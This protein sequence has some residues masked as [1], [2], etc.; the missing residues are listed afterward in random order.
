MS[1]NSKSTKG[2][3]DESKAGNF[4]SNADLKKAI[5]RKKDR[6]AASFRKKIGIKDPKRSR[7]YFYSD[8]FYRSREWLTLRMFALKNTGATCQCCGAKAS[9]GVQIHVDHIKP[10]YTHPELSLSLTNLQVL[11]SDCNIG[12]GAWDDTDWREH[13]K[14]I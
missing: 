7:E 9:D 5:K 8:S 11:C 2:F 12:K 13:W 1:K 6:Q 3:F 10:R 14:S 4:L